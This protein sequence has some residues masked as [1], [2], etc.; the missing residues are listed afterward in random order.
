MDGSM[1]SKLAVASVGGSNQLCLC[2]AVW[3]LSQISSRASMA[4]V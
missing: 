2:A 3:A 1:S 4:Q